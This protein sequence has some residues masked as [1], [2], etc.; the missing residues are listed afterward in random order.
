M[1]GEMDKVKGRI[2]QAAGDLAGDDDLER[3]GE[4]DEAAGKLKDKVDNVKDDVDDAI[5]RVKD[6]FNS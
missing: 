5:D 4:R 6:K 3:N 1:S 2:K